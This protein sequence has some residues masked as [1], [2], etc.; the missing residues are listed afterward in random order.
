M[1]FILKSTLTS[2]Y[3]CCHVFILILL[4]VSQG[5]ELQTVFSDILVMIHTKK[6]L[7]HFLFFIDSTG[8]TDSQTAKLKGLNRRVVTTENKI[9]PQSEVKT[10]RLKIELKPEG[11]TVEAGGRCF[12]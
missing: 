6:N 10:S 7:G 9:A 3:T 4:F 1:I 5:P 12:Q 2:S 11:R 8:N